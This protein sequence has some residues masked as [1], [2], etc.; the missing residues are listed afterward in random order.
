MTLPFEQQ[1]EIPGMTKL[2]G[3]DVQTATPTEHIIENIK[4]NKNSARIYNTIDKL[5][6]WREQRPIAIVGGGPSL[7]KELDNLRNYECI[8]A[9]GSVHDYLLE[10]NITPNWCAVCDPDPIVSNYLKHKKNC[11]ESKP[12]QYLV[13]SQCAPEVFNHLI[14]CDVHMWHLM[15]DKFDHS[16]YGDNQVLIG[17]GCTILTRAM[18]IAMGM[19]F[20]NLNLFGCDTSLGL[21]SE[22][23]AY[24][25]SDPSKE[26]THDEAKVQFER[27][28][29]IFKVAGYHLGQLFDIKALSKQYQNRM[30]ITVH[31]ESLLHYFMELAQK[32]LKLKKEWDLKNGVNSGLNGSGPA[33][34]SSSENSPQP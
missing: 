3:I 29:P 20:Y 30:Q 4:K 1:F 31:G 24:E 15:G 26:I 8:L 7:T 19:G 22:H 25:W 11:V 21:N 14:D 32:R 34:V 10:N 6:S 23:H 2:D 27:D 9:C 33:S 12:I 18:V 13:A 17:G 5:P 16:V 28:G